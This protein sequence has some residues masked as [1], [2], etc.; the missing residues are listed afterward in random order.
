MPSH[1][2]RRGRVSR[3]ASRPACCLHLSCALTDLSNLPRNIPRAGRFTAASQKY[4]CSSACLCLKN[5][6]SPNL[7]RCW[8]GPSISLRDLE[9]SCTASSPRQPQTLPD[10]FGLHFSQPSSPLPS[11]FTSA[12]IPWALDTLSS[13]LPLPEPHHRVWVQLPAE[14]PPMLRPAMLCASAAARRGLSCRIPAAGCSK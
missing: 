12:T 13:G 11:L 10:P 7:C 2:T 1:W 8:F 3:G 6:F 9:T 5:T 4:F 14:S